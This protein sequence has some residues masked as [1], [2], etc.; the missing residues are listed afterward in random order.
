[1]TAVAYTRYRDNSGAWRNPPIFRKTG[2]FSVAAGPAARD[3]RAKTERE[4]AMAWDFET[5]P[6]YQ[7]KLDWVQAFVENE[8]EPLT[9]IGVG[10]GGV[11]SKT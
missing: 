2:I 9:H 11:K 4:N 10:L 6:E 5:D 1:M 3:N 7:K 8:V